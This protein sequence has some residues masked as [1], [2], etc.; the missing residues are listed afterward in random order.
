MEQNDILSNKL[1][2]EITKIEK[3][4]ASI[5]LKKETALI[6]IRKQFPKETFIEITDKICQYGYSDEKMVV[7][8]IKEKEAKKQKLEYDDYVAILRMYSSIEP[9]IN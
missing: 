5:Q 3:L 7:E 1:I 8:S 6:E 9:N 4:E 2:K